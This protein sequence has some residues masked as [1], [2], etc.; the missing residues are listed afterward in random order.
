M[1]IVPLGKFDPS[2]VAAILEK[3]SG[4]V[5]EMEEDLSENNEFGDLE[6]VL[7]AW[8]VASRTAVVPSIFG[9]GTLTFIPL[10]VR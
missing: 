9:G 10:G 5:G 7:E 2:F 4:V 6:A 8:V 3:E 1:L